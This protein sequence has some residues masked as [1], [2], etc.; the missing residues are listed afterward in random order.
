MEYLSQYNCTNNINN[1]NINL[2]SKSR[3]NSVESYKFN[4]DKNDMFKRYQ[5]FD[6]NK[7]SMDIID[8]NDL[9]MKNIFDGDKIVEI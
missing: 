2:V 5:G 6:E 1:Q 3:K 7:L 4:T 9:L 8:M